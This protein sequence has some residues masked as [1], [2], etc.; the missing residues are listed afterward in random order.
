MPG[1]CRESA[2]RRRQPAISHPIASTCTRPMLDHY[3]LRSPRA[4]SGRAQ[5]IGRGR[6]SGRPPKPAS[7]RECVERGLS[8]PRSSLD[9]PQ[10]VRSG[11]L[12]VKGVEISDDRARAVAIAG[13]LTGV[14]RQE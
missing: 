7:E 2:R 11:A 4:S 14:Q 13:P 6:L 9:L 5:A 8:I 1:P 10:L 3:A 12:R